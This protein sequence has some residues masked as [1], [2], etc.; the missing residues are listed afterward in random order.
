MCII[1]DANKLGDF[2]NPRHQESEPIR[3]WLKRK[4]KL[5]Y[6]TSGKFAKEIGR[7]NREKLK[8][9]WQ[10]G[11][12]DL[13]SHK[14]FIAEEQAFKNCA[15]VKPD[16]PHILALVQHTGTRLLYTEDLNLI[17]DFKNNKLIHKPRGKVYSR[18]KNA[19]LLT[20]TACPKK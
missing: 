8:R 16:D 19:D 9:H 1:I 18:A 17:K 5:I 20:D 4:G 10:K 6:S 11:E 13:V 15:L 3:Q 7:G 12:A 14:E 2:L